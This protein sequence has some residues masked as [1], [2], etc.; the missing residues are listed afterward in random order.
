MKTVVWLD[1]SLENVNAG[2][3]I[4]AEAIESQGLSGLSEA[5]R[6]TT[7]RYLRRN[8]VS[9]LRSADVV[10]VGGTNILRSNL[11]T[12][13]Q[14]PIT[15]WQVHAMRHK[16]V[17]LGVGWWQYQGET[18]ETTARTM[19]YLSHPTIP[20]SVRDLYTAQRLENMNIACLMTSC[21]T[22]WE[23]DGR[24]TASGV[25]GMATVATTI[26][27]YHFAA[28]TDAQWLRILAQRFR[29][30]LVVGMGPG[31]K[32][33]LDTV[34]LPENIR[35][36]GYGTEG[37]AQARSLTDLHVGTRLHAGVRWMQSDGRSLILA[38]DNR[39]TEISR[40]TDLP[41]LDRADLDGIVRWL[42]GEAPAVP[43]RIPR[44]PV[45][46]WRSSWNSFVA[47]KG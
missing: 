47:A 33:A 11:W 45:E 1:P 32:A 19:R 4:I 24:S 26:T 46:A 18:K 15:P 34:S 38:V 27:D 28:E 25:A 12:S 2:D 43:V 21:P 6:L 5:V 35:W 42:D 13:R 20:H 16:T 30:V 37:L 7:H 44:N 36:S 39:A 17:L 14:W 9:L 31:D 8:E 10:L 22:M 3:E 40:D 41:V 29:E 23:I